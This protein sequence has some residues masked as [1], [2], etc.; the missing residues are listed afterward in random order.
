M[1][2]KVIVCRLLLEKIPHQRRLH[3]HLILKLNSRNQ[4]DLFHKH[5][6]KESIH[7]ENIKLIKHKNSLYFCRKFNTQFKNVSTVIN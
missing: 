3:A 6:I 2:I 5:T 4:H 7:S 1:N